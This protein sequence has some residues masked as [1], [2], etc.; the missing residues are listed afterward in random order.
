MSRN[1]RMRYGNPPAPY[2]P[3]QIIVRNRK[4]GVSHTLFTENDNELIIDI[5][6]VLQPHLGIPLHHIILMTP[7]ENLSYM[8][9]IYDD[10]TISSKAS[11]NLLELQIIDVT[12]WSEYDIA[13]M[14]ESW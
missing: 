1:Y 5:K 3:T 11:N 7:G 4:N 12:G 2:V 14:F 8:N 13:T 9:M 6:N 10:Q